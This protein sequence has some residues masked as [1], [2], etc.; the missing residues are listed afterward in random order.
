[1]HL[2]LGKWPRWH[3]WKFKASHLGGR[4]EGSGTAVDMH[5]CVLGKKKK[6]NQRETDVMSNNCVIMEFILKKQKQNSDIQNQ[7]LEE[8]HQVLVMELHHM[9][10]CSH[11]EA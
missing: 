3:R 2:L 10:T 4:G 8:C 6:Q 11:R 9:A 1:M 5:I 7:P